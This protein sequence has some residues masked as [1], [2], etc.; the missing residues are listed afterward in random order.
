MPKFRNEFRNLN[1]EFDLNKKID[2]CEFEYSD[3]ET[4]IDQINRVHKIKRMLDS[5]QQID[6]PL[7]FIFVD[8]PI[9]N[10]GLYS[11]VKPQA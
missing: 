9:K 1:L 7:M 3:G 10:P 6:S 2:K 5:A 8:Y 11:Q 4:L